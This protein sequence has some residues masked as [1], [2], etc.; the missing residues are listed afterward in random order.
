MDLTDCKV[1][2]F[3][4]KWR[5][6]EIQRRNW[7]P[8]WVANGLPLLLYWSVGMV[9]TVGLVP[10]DAIR[11]WWLVD[12]SI[13]LL[14]LVVAAGPLL[15]L[16]GLRAVHGASYDEYRKIQEHMECLMHVID[17]LEDLELDPVSKKTC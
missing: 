6:A 5:L 8:L 14:G 15:L 10:R 17:Y 7:P 9:F 1:E 11:D 2:L 3:H 12:G 4:A 13:A 16:H